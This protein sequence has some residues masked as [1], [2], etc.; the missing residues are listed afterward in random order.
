MSEL[1][2][3]ALGPT[4]HA[5]ARAHRARLGALLAPHG[6]HPGQDLLL[7]AVWDTP[8][9]GQSA[10]AAQL[11]VEPPTVTRMVQ[12]LERGGMVERRADPLDAR[13]QLVYAT[14]RSR[15][16]ESMVRR[17]WTS[18]DELLIAELGDGD[19][20]KLQKLAARAVMA[21]SPSS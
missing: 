4:L 19:A 3:D 18:L 11:G 14:P 2:A 1:P 8:G 7:L 21:L 20:V 13:A 12:R 10:L 9:I 16:L 6:L 15:I 5:L 17:A